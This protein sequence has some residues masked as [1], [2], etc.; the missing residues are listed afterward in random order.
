MKGNVTGPSKLVDISHLPG[1]DR[2]EDLADGG[3]QIGAL[4]RNA[5]LARDQDLPGAFR[6]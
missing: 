4:M 5:D 1:L 2:V 3:V 6:R